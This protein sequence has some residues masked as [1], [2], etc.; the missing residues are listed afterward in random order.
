LLAPPVLALSRETQPSRKSEAELTLPGQVC[1]FDLLAPSQVGAAPHASRFRRQIERA[2]VLSRG[3]ELNSEC[4]CAILRPVKRRLSLAWIQQT[5]TVSATPK[6]LDSI[7]LRDPPLARGAAEIRSPASKPA[8]IPH[9]VS[10]LTGQPKWKFP[11]FDVTEAGILTT[12]S[13]LLFTG[14]REGYFYALDARTGELLW[15]A[16][17]GGQIAMAPIT[18]QVGGKQYVSV[19]SGHTLVTFALRD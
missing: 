18:F 19:I 2:D 16:S 13:D 1:F 3:I 9:N 14:G 15:R 17:L 7:Q 12:A 8:R 10:W 11:Q 5:R 4:L 6:P